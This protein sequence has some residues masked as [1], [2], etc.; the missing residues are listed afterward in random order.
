[1]WEVWGM[2]FTQWY[3]FFFSFS[4]EPTRCIWVGSPSI[5]AETTDLPTLGCSFCPVFVCSL[6]WPL[7]CVKWPTSV[8]VFISAGFSRWFPWWH[9][10]KKRDLLYW[11]LNSSFFLIKGEGRRLTFLLLLFKPHL[12][13][14][15]LILEREEKRKGRERK[16]DVREKHLS[17]ASYVPRPGAKPAMWVC[18]LTENQTHDISV[19]G[20]MLQPTEPPGQG[21]YQCFFKLWFD[22][23]WVMKSI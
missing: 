14:C 9:V 16:I 19:D 1:M 17:V 4:T 2:C 13:T 7:Y 10:N 23:G 21:P 12:K 15:L 6:S 11:G 8:E 20:T 5:G 3:L 18:V 22:S